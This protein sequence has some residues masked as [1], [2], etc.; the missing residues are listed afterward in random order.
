MVFRDRKDAGMQL[1]R[2]LGQYKGRPD[3]LVLALPRGGV[4]TGFEIACSLNVSFDVFIVRKLGFPGQPELAIGAL[5]ETGAVILNRDLITLFGIS[6]EYIESEIAVQGAEIARRAD[7]YRHGGVMTKPMG[8]TVILVDDGVATGATM[9][10]AI[11]ALREEGA[12]MLIIA[13]PV[14]PPEMVDELKQLS[15]ELI[16]METPLSFMSVGSYY[17]DF[18]QVADEE[19]AA[20]LQQATTVRGAQ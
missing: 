7:L 18:S 17:D 8:K 15:D 4:I 20:V 5:A 16:C 9:K 6:N 12:D 1:A 19:V 3:V 14:A 10:A 2:R 11:T 13:V